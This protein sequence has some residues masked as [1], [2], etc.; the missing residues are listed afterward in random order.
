MSRRVYAVLFAVIL[1][2]VLLA[3]ATVQ[4]LPSS[5]DWQTGDKPAIDKDGTGTKY[6][7]SGEIRSDPNHITIPMP[8][9]GIRTRLDSGSYVWS[10]GDEFYINATT[11]YSTQGKASGTYRL[12]AHHYIILYYK[13][14]ALNY[15]A[16]DSYAYPDWNPYL[17]ASFSLT[18]GSTGM[19]T[20]TSWSN[21]SIVYLKGAQGDYSYYFQSNS[22]A[23]GGSA[24]G[25]VTVYSG[26]YVLK[27]H[28]W[29]QLTT[30]NSGGGGSGGYNVPFTISIAVLNQ[31]EAANFTA[32]VTGSWT[33]VNDN[34][35]HDID[36][37]L[38]S[39]YSPS[40]QLNGEIFQ[41]KMATTR[42]PGLIAGQL[43][44]TKTTPTSC[45]WSRCYNNYGEYLTGTYLVRA[46]FWTYSSGDTISYYTV[47]PSGQT[48]GMPFS[49]QDF[50]QGGHIIR[51]FQTLSNQN[52]SIYSYTVSM[53]SVSWS[54][55]GYQPVVFEFQYWK[56]T[57]LTSSGWQTVY[58]PSPSF[59]I[60]P[61]K[62]GID[63][64]TGVRAEA[65]F[66]ARPAST[67]QPVI[68]LGLGTMYLPGEGISTPWLENMIGWSWEGIWT[69]NVTEL[70]PV[71]E[72]IAMI[73]TD[74]SNVRVVDL[75][76]GT[77]LR[78]YLPAGWKN[79]KKVW[80]MGQAKVTQI[81]Q[82]RD[83]L[84][85]TFPAVNITVNGNT[86]TWYLVA[87]AAWNPYKQPNDGYDTSCWLA[88]GT[89][90][91]VYNLTY[92][93]TFRNGTRVV[94]KEPVVVSSLKTAVTP[95]YRIGDMKQAL[96]LK[97]AV[98]WKYLPPARTGI[99]PQ[100]PS[101]IVGVA[102]IGDRVYN[103][104]LIEA[105]ATSKTFLVAITNDTWTLYS[106]GIN[107]IVASAYW[108]SSMGTP[109][110]PVALQDPAQLNIVYVML[111]FV[112]TIQ[113]NFDESKIYVDN[114]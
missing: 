82:D 73:L 112:Y 84:A 107:S 56:L 33:G 63:A 100:P 54:I 69:L 106:K 81:P 96:M 24:V 12:V 72:H 57:Y 40:M 62:L 83:T 25:G 103:G 46:E 109:E 60:Q 10:H 42:V 78:V 4:A 32:R 87:L 76:N 16:T 61:G 3:L 92:T 68:N 35:W 43:L 9:Y 88:N 36:S 20:V 37:Q 91:A 21:R 34:Y 2:A 97:V 105:N 110:G 111:S 48:I 29:F 14:T 98:K 19:K 49:R 67:Q 58:I 113:R 8:N 30:P 53:G 1:L 38:H 7:F 99:Q 101:S 13:D 27:L 22:G 80:T 70:Y 94:F 18:W 85:K 28:S 86:E 93:Y 52:P 104:T 114:P 89:T 6:T 95:D 5:E 11:L 23:L 51:S 45:S 59:Q 77:S 66:V 31:T 102:V 75:P 71:K 15:S 65:Y 108:L 90:L 64:Q 55:Y 79:Y 41:V 50:Y 26:T 17:Y 44:K 74:G 47:T 39:L